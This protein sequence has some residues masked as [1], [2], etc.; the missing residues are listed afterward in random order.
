[1]RPT[2]FVVQLF[3]SDLTV[4]TRILFMYSTNRMLVCSGV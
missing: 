3:Q 1:V 2:C 4:S